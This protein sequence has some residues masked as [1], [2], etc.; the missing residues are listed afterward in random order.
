MKVWFSVVYA[1]MVEWIGC[2]GCHTSF[3]ATKFD[4]RVHPMEATPRR[5]AYMAVLL[6]NDIRVV[7]F[8][9]PANGGSWDLVLCSITRAEVSR[10]S[11]NPS[12]QA[13]QRAMFT[14][15]NPNSPMH[16]F[17]SPK[18]ASQK[19]QTISESQNMIDKV[20]KCARQGCL[21]LIAWHVSWWNDARKASLQHSINLCWFACTISVLGTAVWAKQ[22]F[23]SF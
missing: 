3:V 23:Q 5:F 6:S 9:N 12:F 13:T 19:D 21:L 18:T 8:V 16:Q 11:Q 15:G 4:T 22:I 7:L 20:D 14:W 2:I 17:W 10:P 1:R